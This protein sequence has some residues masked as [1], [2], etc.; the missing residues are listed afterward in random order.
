M[1][2]APRIVVPQGGDMVAAPR[3]AAP[4][5]GDMVAEEEAPLGG[6]DMEDERSRV[7]EVSWSATSH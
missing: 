4:Q 1:A 3:T 6:A 7:L 5:G 2:A